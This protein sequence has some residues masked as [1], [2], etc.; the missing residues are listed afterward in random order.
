M[1]QRRDALIAALGSEIVRFQDASNAVDDAA[2]AVL[3][4][5]RADLQCISFLL[6]GGAAS[7]TQLRGALQLDPRA[8]RAMLERLELA[9]YVRRVAASE[10]SRIELTEHA[11]GWVETLWGPLADE[12]RRILARQSTRDLQTMAR[13]MDA[14]RPVQ[15]NHAARIRA[16]LD[17]PGAAGTRKSRLRGGLSPAAA[18]RVQ[19]YVTA[20][21]D[22]PIRIADLAGRAGLSAFHFARA[23]KI[24]MGV[25]PLDFVRDR[26]IDRARELL[27]DSELGLA[28]IAEATG[29]GSQSRFTTVFRR[30]TGFTPAAYRR[31]LR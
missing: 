1:A 22:R 4:L 7:P 24:T 11:R 29:L 20:H 18:R 9:G 25:T 27:R 16:L 19:L 17:V 6:F 15:E 28:A 26:R 14:I 10:G 13:F 23:F 2:A 31:G 21:L 8:L 5:E 3:A 12:G 30:A